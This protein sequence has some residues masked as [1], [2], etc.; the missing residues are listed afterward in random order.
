MKKSASGQKLIGDETAFKARARKAAAGPTGGVDDLKTLLQNEVASLEKKIA[1]QTPPD[2]TVA[3]RELK[4][5][6]NLA[7]QGLVVNPRILSIER[8]RCRA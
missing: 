8:T 7:E 4:G 6:D 5:I 3:Q 1:T 2:R